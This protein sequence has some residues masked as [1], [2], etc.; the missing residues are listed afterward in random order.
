MIVN[1][2]LSSLAQKTALKTSVILTGLL[3]ITSCSSEPAKVN[4]LFAEQPVEKTQSQPPIT[5][6]DG[7]FETEKTDLVVTPAPEEEPTPEVV[8]TETP[9]QETDS[10]NSGTG[11]E[12]SKKPATSNEG[13]SGSGAQPAPQSQP[14]NTEPA[15]YSGPTVGGFFLFTSSNAQVMATAVDEISS[16]G[17][18]TLITFGS[19]VKPANLVGNRPS[20]DA[21]KNCTVKGAGCL[22]SVTSN[23]GINKLFTYEDKGQ[24]SSSAFRCDGEQSL[25]SDNGEKYTI[26]I[27]PR[28]GNCY[29]NPDVVVSKDSKVNANAVML[30]EANKRGMKVFVGLPAPVMRGDQSWLPDMSYTDTLNAFTERFL[31]NYRDT[32]SNNGALRG[33]Y[34]HV[35]MP[36]KT[37]N[38][39]NDV[40]TLY[41]N[42]NKL[43]KQITPNY[44]ALISPYM[45]A[46][47]N[48]AANTPLNEISAATRLLAETSHGTHLIIAPQDGQGTGKVGAFDDST[49][50]NQVDA[51]SAAIAGNGTY[52]NVY[53]AGTGA[54]MSEVVKG[55]SGAEIWVNLELMAASTQGADTCEKASNG[56]GKTTIERVHEQR[57]VGT[58]PGVSKTI[59]FM[60]QPY[61]TCGANSLFQGLR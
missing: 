61:T 35:E 26:I 51:P 15:V 58:P 48:Y 31:I 41:S 5:I 55:A 24:W 42:Q 16:T 1:M 27:L 8:V 18:D 14:N 36:L 38:S 30:E 59:G 17:A 11:N 45:D 33:F 22:S 3:L 60:W 6:E 37:S 52:A 32:Y 25:T 7:E 28:D 12:N 20:G 47:K 49:K 4:S 56:R 53:I 9:V 57:R 29:N 54:Y 40:R 23:R 13:N 46:R 44:H 50:N 2:L 10:N 34:H 43:I 39:W 19:R 21:F